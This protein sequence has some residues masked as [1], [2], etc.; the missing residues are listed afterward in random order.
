MKP[1]LTSIEREGQPYVDEPVMVEVSKVVPLSLE[2]ARICGRKIRPVIDTLSHYNHV[3]L[4]WMRP[5][6]R[7]GLVPRNQ[8]RDKGPRP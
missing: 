2:V 7:G 5:D 4:H 3:R 6:G 8:P 1:L